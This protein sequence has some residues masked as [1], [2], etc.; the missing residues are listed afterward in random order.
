MNRYLLFLPGIL[1]LC[2]PVI[3]SMC[4]AHKAKVAKRKAI[5]AKEA[6]EAAR[7]EA[8]RKANEERE[9]RK[10]A[11]EAAKAAQPKRKPGRPRKNP[12]PEQR[13]ANISPATPTPVAPAT[14]APAT[15]VTPALAAVPAAA[16]AAPVAEAPKPTKY[17]GNNA[18]AGQT[19]AFTGA[20]PGMTRSEAIKAV[21]KNGGKAFES[22]PAATTLLVVGDRP[23]R[24]K[25]DKAD[26]WNVRKITCVGCAITSASSFGRLAMNQ[27]MARISVMFRK[28]SSN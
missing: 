8:L 28:P 26:D 15:P 5:A 6:R 23:G 20:L 18:F 13:P 27:A 16:P 14:P 24:R 1:I 10:A 22:M 12:A 4:D 21:E 11:E 2:L 7:R 25:L 17:V 19:V 9:A 3:K